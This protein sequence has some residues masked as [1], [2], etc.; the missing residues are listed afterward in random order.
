MSTNQ[1]QKFSL[2]KFKTEDLKISH[3]QI[4]SL[5]II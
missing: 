3:S 5:N 1:N 4:L 2:T